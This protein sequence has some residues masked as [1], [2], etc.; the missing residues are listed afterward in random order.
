MTFRHPS[1]LGFGTGLHRS[2]FGKSALHKKGND[3]KLDCGTLSAQQVKFE[4][5]ESHSMSHDS[6]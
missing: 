4:S 6:V 1:K 2:P 5:V 3:S